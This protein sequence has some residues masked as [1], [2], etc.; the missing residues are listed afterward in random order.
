MGERYPAG[1]QAYKMKQTFSYKNWL[2][3]SM[4]GD[5]DIHTFKQPDILRQA[6]NETKGLLV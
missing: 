5:Y 4:F 1:R 2:D 6:G 3:K